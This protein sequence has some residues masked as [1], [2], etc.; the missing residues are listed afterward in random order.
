MCVRF[1]PGA[2]FDLPFCSPELV[3]ERRRVPTKDTEEIFNLR[4]YNFQTIRSIENM[5]NKNETSAGGVVFRKKGKNYEVLI[6][7][8][9]GYH[10]WVLPKGLVEQGETHEQTAVR[11]VKEE[12]GVEARIIKPLGEPE[13]YIYTLNG[14]RIFKKVYYFLMEYVGGSEQEHDFEMEDVVWVS[15]DEAIERMGFEGA[16]NVLKQA[17]KEL[18]KE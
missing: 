4:I 17:K 8:H 9:S 1:A 14:V 2:L 3:E 16:K 6:S 12:V 11:E 18:E 7:K 13:S 10:K 5:E 15:I